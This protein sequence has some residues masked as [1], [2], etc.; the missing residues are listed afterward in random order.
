[1]KNDDY[2]GFFCNWIID[3]CNVDEVKYISY[4]LL[5]FK[6]FE[7]IKIKCLNFKLVSY[8]FF[9][10]GYFNLL[11]GESFEIVSSIF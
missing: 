10:L 4:V 2:Y 11:C 7:N 8:D 5:I 1:M 9:C 6:I 3:Y